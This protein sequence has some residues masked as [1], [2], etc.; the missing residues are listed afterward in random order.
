MDDNGQYAHDPCTVGELYTLVD[1]LNHTTQ[2]E[3]FTVPQTL[4]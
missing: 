1:E 3:R 4:S 2:V